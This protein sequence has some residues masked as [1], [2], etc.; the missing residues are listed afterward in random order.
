MEKAI[1]NGV[2]I[3]NIMV[4]GAKMCNKAKSWVAGRM[5]IHMMDIG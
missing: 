3:Q 2:L 4:I 5:S 1:S